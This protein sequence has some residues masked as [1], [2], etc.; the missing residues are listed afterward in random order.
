MADDKQQD[1]APLN[2]VVITREFTEDGNFN[3]TI[4]ETGDVK[5]TETGDILRYA[6][7]L[8]DRKFKV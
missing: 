6:L 3:L 8:H 4:G 5:R 1:D 2:A 7:A